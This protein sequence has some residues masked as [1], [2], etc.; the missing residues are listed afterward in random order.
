MSEAAAEKVAGIVQRAADRL[1]RISGVAAVV[2]GGSWS[3]GGSDSI[4]DVD[5]GVYY[6]ASAPPSVEALR[7]AAAELD[8]G[9]SPA[10]AT[11][12]GEWGAWVNG[13]AWLTVGDQRVDWLYRELERVSATIDDCV[14]GRPTCHYYLGHPHGFH[15]HIYLAEVHYCRPLFDPHGVLQP[16]KERLRTYPPRLKEA[17]IRTYSYDASF[18]LE[19]ARKP[20]Q[21][22][23]V[24][25]VSGCLFRCAA[26]LIQ[27]LFA[28]NERYFMN[29][30]GSLSL[31]DQFSSRP[32]D[33]SRR[34]AALLSHPGE[35][36]EPLAESLGAMGVLLEETFEIC[37]E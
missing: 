21:R 7:Q 11:D 32:S 9:S 14:A 28:L 30:K 8:T 33:F 4:S 34:V 16:L 3:R 31:T 22:G 6:R 13:G 20:A 24:F 26:A 35:S 27:V 5:L 18:M 37:R 25:H 36:S 12:F 10:A 17:L 19:L 29:E 15:N 2:L 23:D 1:S